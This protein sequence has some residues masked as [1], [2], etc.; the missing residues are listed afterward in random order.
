MDGSQAQKTS[1]VYN[2]KLAV[3]IYLEPNKDRHQ[4]RYI[5]M[6]EILL[7]NSEKQTKKAN[8]IVV[9][10]L[11]PNTGKVIGIRTKKEFRKRKTR[12]VIPRKTFF[13][14]KNM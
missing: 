9:S 14:E 12:K 7:K 6:C 1:E 5:S 3:F 8:A 10:N 2:N 11:T 4:P 13:R